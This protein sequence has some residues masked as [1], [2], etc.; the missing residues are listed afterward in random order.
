MN[1]IPT[2]AILLLGLSLAG[3]TDT[4]EITGEDWRTLDT[5]GD[6]A[7]EIQEAYKLESHP[8]YRIAESAGQIEVHLPDPEVN[9][10]SLAAEISKLE[11]V[12]SFAGKLYV[13]FRHTPEGSDTPTIWIKYDAKTGK[14]REP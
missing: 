5:I 8:Y 4:L 12:R 1:R 3:C 14:P 2:L 10:P 11:S 6:I 7:A 9:H 13:V